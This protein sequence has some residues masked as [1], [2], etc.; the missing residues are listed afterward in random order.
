MNRNREK[1]QALWST[2][3]AS[4]KRLT[5]ATWLTIFRIVLTPVIVI[6]R[7]QGA[8]ALACALFV[9]AALTDFLDGFL[10]RVRN[11]QT[12]LGA[13]LDPLADKILIVSCFAV[14]ALHDSTALAVPVWFVMMMLV[15]ELI[16]CIGAHLCVYPHRTYRN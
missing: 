7:I 5:L 11:E 15:K 1:A 16:L 9:V 14:F 8:W 10:A 6:A 4:E 13:M 3:P 12:V 2:L